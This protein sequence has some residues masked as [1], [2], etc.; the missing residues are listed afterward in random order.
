VNEYPGYSH[1]FQFKF[2]GNV[3]LTADA[4][5]GSDAIVQ[6]I[7]L[8]DAP[9]TYLTLTNRCMATSPILTSATMLDNGAFQFYFSNTQA[10]SFTVLTTTNLSV[11]LSNWTVLGAPSN[12]A[13]NLFQFTSEPT[14]NDPQR[15]Y[16]VRSP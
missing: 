8:D 14:T 15:Y 1:V 3:T 4:T 5:G 7:F 2:R 13:P 12:I 16:R 9:V 6:S 11:P 10:A